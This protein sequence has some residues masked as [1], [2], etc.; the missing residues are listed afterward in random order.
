METLTITVNDRTLKGKNFLNFLKSLDFV[1]IDEPNRATKN[2]I[3]ELENG[4]GKKFKN[5][6]QA[7]SFL[8]K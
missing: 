8:K 3:E 4:R 2:A 7:I 5:A 1:K 6:S